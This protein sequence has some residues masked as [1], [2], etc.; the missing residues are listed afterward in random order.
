MIKA[1][2]F[3]C[4]G[5]LCLD[6]WLPFKE[7]HFGKGTDLFRK[8]TESNKRADTGLISYETFL[9]EVAQ[10]ANIPFSEAKKQIE[11][12]PANEEL[13]A[14]ISSIL[15]PKYKIGILSNAAENWLN[16]LFT[17]E[18]LGLFDATALSFELGFIKPDKRA[19]IEIAQRLGLELEQCIFV[20]DQERY[21]LGAREAGMKAIVYKDFESLKAELEKLL[22]YTNA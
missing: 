10:L 3:D 20:D 15:K 18:H 4:F 11:N 22:T 6:G 13:F 14:Y 1:I 19:Y 5:V 9:K 7:K 16:E 8:A 2:I 17:A 21:C 12:N